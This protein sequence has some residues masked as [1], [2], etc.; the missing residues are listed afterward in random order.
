MHIPRRRFLELASVGVLATGLPGRGMLAAPGIA[1]N[2]LKNIGLQLSTVTPLLFADFEGTL[3]RV[4]EVGYTKVEFSAVG[5]FGRPLSHVRQQLEDHGLEAPVGRVGP[6]LS[7][8]AFELPANEF[9]K[10]LIEKSRNEYFIEN[11]KYSIE[12]AEAMGQKH[13]VLPVF[14]PDNFK[15]LDKVKESI[16]LLNRA[17][18]LC[19]ERGILFGYHNH[20][21]E[22]K[23]MEG[24]IPYDLMLDELDPEQV[25]FQLD[26]YW[27]VKGG[28]DLADYLARYA[29]R[30][31]SC[32]L[33][34]IDAKG[35]FADVG[36]GE[37]DFPAFV[38]AAIAQGTKHFFVERDRPPDPLTSMQRS[39]DYLSQMTLSML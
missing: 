20:D 33:K 24:V 21:W 26:S 28:G 38:G 35:D 7:K 5:A 39:F 37:I 16:E 11:V 22:L 23:P 2:R 4:A 29:G 18:E 13:V 12:D 25:S 15:S 3:A 30:F 9:I 1:E 19:A 36:H 34:D 31:P 14:L 10:T 8:D 27:I 32:H 6:R 17:G